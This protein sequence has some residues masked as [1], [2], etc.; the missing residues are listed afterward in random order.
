MADMNVLLIM[1]DEMDGRKM[2]C[3]GWESMHTPNL[4]A[5]AERGTI[6]ENTYC[7]SPLCVPSRASFVTGRHVHEIHCWDNGSPF[8]DCWDTF[9]HRL[10]DQGVPVTTFGKIDFVE[11][12]GDH[13][14]ERTFKPTRRNPGDICGL[15]RDPLCRRRNARERLQ[16]AGPKDISGNI[17]EEVYDRSIEFLR[18]DEAQDGPWMLWSSYRNPHFAH[19]APEEYYEMYPEDEVELPPVGD[20]SKLNQLN[21]DLRYHFEVDELIDEETWMRNVRGYHGLISY[22][23]NFVGGLMDTLDEEGLADDTV[24]IFTSD[25]GEML[26]SHGMWWKCA[27]FEPSVRVPLIMAG[28]DIEAGQRVEHP[29]SQVNM[30]PTIVDAAECELESDDEDL[31]GVS[32]LPMA[33]EGDDDDLPKTVFSQYHAHGVRNGWFLVRKDDLKLIHYHGYGHEMYDVGEDPDEAKDLALDPDMHHQLASLDGMIHDELNPDV[34]DTTAK[35]DQSA[36]KIWVREQLGE[37]EFDEMI[38]GKC[39]FADDGDEG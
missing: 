5:L 18:S 17:D 35:A 23:D 20:E 14:F 27:P 4:D 15:F 19:F 34:V 38:D 25:H 22:V 32:L 12:C 21:R 11:P 36:R 39:D 29:V 30:F 10:E 28:P 6:F 13:G 24:V 1:V 2:G 3:A 8:D 31:P 33:R 7:A 37:D 9:G 16:K 26:G